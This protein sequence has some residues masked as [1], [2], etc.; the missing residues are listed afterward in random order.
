MGGFKQESF[1]LSIEQQLK[2]EMA[3]RAATSL[4]REELQELL[5]E[6]M[7][8]YFIKENLIKDLIRQLVEA[9]L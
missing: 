3:N 7:R 6:L 5:A 2:I 1:A 4:S 8:S 9:G